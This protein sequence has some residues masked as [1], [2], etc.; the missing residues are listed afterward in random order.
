MSSASGYMGEKVFQEFGPKFMTCHMAEPDQNFWAGPTSPEGSEGVGPA[1]ASWTRKALRRILVQI[2]KPGLS[3]NSYG[4]LFR[5][6]L[7]WKWFCTTNP[8][9]ICLPTIWVDGFVCAWCFWFAFLQLARACKF[10]SIS[11]YIA[12]HTWVIFQPATHHAF[13]WVLVC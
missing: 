10:R 3:N 2:I 8:P 7:T 1:P 6:A 4:W 12:K 5:L 13:I 11:C 9:V